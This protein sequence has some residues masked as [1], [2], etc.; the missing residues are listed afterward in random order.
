MGWATF[1]VKFWAI[2]SKTHLVTDAPPEVDWKKEA[3]RLRE[4]ARKKSIELMKKQWK[5]QFKSLGI[6]KASTTAAVASAGKY[7]PIELGQ[8]HPFGEI[9]NRPI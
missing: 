3:A 2:F 8:L 4:E 5:S 7:M 1:W 6:N 9:K